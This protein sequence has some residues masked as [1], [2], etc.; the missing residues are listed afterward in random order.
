MP[1]AKI[2]DQAGIVE[3]NP[4]ATNPKLTDAGSWNVI[5]LAARDDAQAVAAGR[6]IAAQFAGKKIALLGDKSAS[7]EALLKAMRATLTAVNQTA[8]IDDPYPPG[9]KDFADLA[10]KIIDAQA[11]V[12]YFSGNYPTPG[13]NRVVSRAFVKYMEGINERAY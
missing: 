13:G 9:G 2:Y 1:A 12:V 10:R 3:L 4:T 6:H 7:S 8:A 11:D 5:R